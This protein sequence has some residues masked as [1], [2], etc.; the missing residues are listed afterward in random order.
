[1][2]NAVLGGGEM[3]TV[4]VS[5]S[6][7][8]AENS[9]D[10]ESYRKFLHTDV[11]WSLYSKDNSIIQGIDDYMNKIKAAYENMDNQFKWNIISIS[12]DNKRAVTLLEDSYGRESLDI[13]DFQDGLIVRE[14]E[15]RL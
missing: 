7:F 6:F 12:R 14:W 15:F 9:R 5:E 8:K 2:F 3:D 13:F 1:M 4:A 10:W 11:T